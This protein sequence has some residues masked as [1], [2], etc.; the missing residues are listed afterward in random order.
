VNGDQVGTAAAPINPLLGPLAD[1]GSF[2]QTRGLL[3]GS[4]ATDAGD[5]AFTVPELIPVLTYDQRGDCCARVINGRIDIGAFE[6]QTLSPAPIA[7][8]GGP[9]AGDE[10]S[11]IALS[12]AS[13]ADQDGDALSYSWSFVRLTPDPAPCEFSDATQ[14]NPTFTCKDD[15]T[16][17]LTLVVSDNKAPPVQS[18]TTLTVNNRAPT[19]TFLAPSPVTEGSPI[20]LLLTSPQDPSPMDQAAGFKYAFDCGDGAGYGPFGGSNAASCPTTDDG[21]RTVKGKIRDK[22]GGEREYVAQVTVDNVAPVVGT[23]TSPLDPQALSQAITVNTS[24]ADFGANDGPWSYTIYWGDGSTSIGTMSSPSGALGGTHAYAGPGIYTVKIVVSDN[25]GAPGAAL[26]SYI[27]VYDPDGGFVTG[28]GVVN[29]PPGAYVPDPSLTGKASFGFVSKYQ[30][31]QTVPAGRTEFRFKT[32]SFTFASTSYEWLVISGARAQ[33]KGSGTVNDA[34]DYGFLLSAI[35][36]ALPG[37]G[38]SD[39]FRIKI[40]NKSTGVV[41]YDN[42]IGDADTSDPR[43][44]VEAGSIVIHQK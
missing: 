9:Y 15:G 42:Q 10:G 17:E 39:K 8:A 24:F 32:A 19:A 40:W 26:S 12:G 28:G 22:D 5:P 6:D 25:D 2:I 36:G 37:G 11:A 35:D 16:F 43:T 44:V 27:V 29:S 30:K 7:S 13:A 14:L 34:G 38:G 23:V 18:T 33:F 21:V 1:N 20:G 31:G 3:P 4:P 41:I